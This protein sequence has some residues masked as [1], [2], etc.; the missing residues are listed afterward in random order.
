M[1]TK[2]KLSTKRVKELWVKNYILSNKNP[3]LATSN[4]TYKIIFKAEVKWEAKFL[5]EKKF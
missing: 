3:K 1:N 2:R 5:L 4:E